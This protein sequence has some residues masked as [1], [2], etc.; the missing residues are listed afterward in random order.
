MTD[1]V[2]RNCVATGIVL[3]DSAFKDIWVQQAAGGA[4]GAALATC[5]RE[6][7]NDWGSCNRMP[8]GLRV[9]CL[10][11]GE[12]ELC[13]MACWVVFETVLEAEMIN[14]PCSGK[15]CGCSSLQS[16]IRMPCG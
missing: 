10:Q 4:V 15:G 3:R 7:G 8:G 11:P 9:S 1:G 6:V 14:P 13:L 5:H 12:F 16:G 2:A